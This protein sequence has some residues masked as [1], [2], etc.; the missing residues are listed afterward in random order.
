ML[1]K[2]FAFISLGCAKN[3]VDSEEII[4]SL[5]SA[6]FQLK[7]NIKKASFAII[8]TC[9]FLKE[10]RSEALKTLKE[11][12]LVKKNPKS[13]LKKIAVI[14]CLA[15]YYN[16]AQIKKLVPEIDLAV[17][18]D[19][20]HAIPD[21]LE[22]MVS[23]RADIK[24]VER[25]KRRFLS[26]SPHSVYIKIAEG[27]NNRCS[28]C[29]IPSLRGRLR[30]R[31]MGDILDEVKAVQKLGT[32]EICLI[33][34]DTTAYGLDYYGKGMIVELLKRLSAVKGI[35][36]IRLLYAHPARVTKDLLNTIKEEPR[37]C[38]YI[39]LPI[40]HISD[41]ILRRMGRM[42]G[43]EKIVSLYND[44]RDLIPDVTLRTTVMTGYP[45][46]G[47]R[48]FNELLNFLK[49]YPFERLGIFP[50]S[51]E[52]GTRAFKQG[53]R[54][55]T[56]VINQ[57]LEKLLEQ[58]KDISREFNRGLLGKRVEVMVDFPHPERNN[59]YGRL[60][61]QAPEVDGKVVITGVSRVHPGDFLPVKISGVGTFDLLGS[62]LDGK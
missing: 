3:L 5:Q 26:G 18:I 25:V 23:P 42:S 43:K 17:T 45:G 30:S 47:E 4:G 6:G 41:K 1:K 8:N 22:R 62:N 58:Q 34:Q 24:E 28:Y 13:Q 12:A 10:A 27:C 46:E 20:Y 9:A 15:Q 50:F 56:E 54:V 2:T 31:S 51:P 60:V 14:G 53:H 48:E 35:Y 19:N 49:E 61:S 40:Q 44:I 39:D 52:R 57:R 7:Q 55:K 33:A 29:L 59:A 36:W 21:L 16:E 37:I 38:K 11:V 32:R